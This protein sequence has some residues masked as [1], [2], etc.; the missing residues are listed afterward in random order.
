MVCLCT[1]YG[2]MV[3]QCSQNFIYMYV[4]I[5]IYNVC[6]C[7]RACVMMSVLRDQVVSAVTRVTNSRSTEL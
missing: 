3:D 2:V 6:M 5:Y 4:C 7:V 1:F